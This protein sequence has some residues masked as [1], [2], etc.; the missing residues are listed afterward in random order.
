MRWNESGRGAVAVEGSPPFAAAF[1]HETLPYLP[2]QDVSF[3]PF[4]VCVLKQTRL[5]M[6]NRLLQP[7]VMQRKHWGHATDGVQFS[8]N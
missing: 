5:F 2:H 1:S 4:A 6:Q 3:V 8:C 7:K